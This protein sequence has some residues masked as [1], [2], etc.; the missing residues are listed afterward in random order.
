VLEKLAKIVDLLGEECGDAEI[1]C[2]GLRLFLR[3]RRR[4]RKTREEKES[5]A[6]VIRIINFT[7]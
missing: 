7:L 4:F 5:V 6:V 3:Q 1:V 2:T